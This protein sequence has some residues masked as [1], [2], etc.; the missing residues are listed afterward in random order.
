MNYH[1]F[2]R[3]VIFT[4]LMTGMHFGTA[5]PLLSAFSL[6]DAEEYI[7]GQETVYGCTIIY[8]ATI[9]LYITTVVNGITTTY[10][11]YLTAYHLML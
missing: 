5:V 7:I 9:V 8:E 10:L 4:L 3:V 6:E 1:Y 2:F 11:I